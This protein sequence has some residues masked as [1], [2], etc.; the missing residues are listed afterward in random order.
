M[1]VCVFFVCVC[2]CLQFEISICKAYVHSK[3]CNST[4][5][6]IHKIYINC[7]GLQKKKHFLFLSFSL[8]ST[9][10]Q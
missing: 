10:L 8:I 4:P 6:I 9:L 5:I 7:N 2:V 3:F 1:C